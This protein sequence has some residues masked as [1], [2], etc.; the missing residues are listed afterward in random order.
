M[1]ALSPFACLALAAL[2]LWLQPPRELSALLVVLA[3]LGICLHAKAL[4][5]EALD[6]Q[7]LPQPTRLL[8]VASTYGDG[9]APTM[10]RASNASCSASTSTC[11][12]WNMPC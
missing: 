5:L 9:E 4:P 2:L 8:L 1:S 12:R 11:A 3:W 6:L 10:P 7:Q